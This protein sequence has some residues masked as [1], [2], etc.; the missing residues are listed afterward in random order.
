MF[1][2][3]VQTIS[4]EKD[5]AMEQNRHLSA[6]N[7]QYLQRTSELKDFMSNL[8]VSEFKSKIYCTENKSF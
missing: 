4:E 8:M 6:A 3:C 5:L 7:E 2:Q 1:I